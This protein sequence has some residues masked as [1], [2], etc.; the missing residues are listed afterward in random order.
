MTFVPGV[1]ASVWEGVAAVAVGAN[2]PEKGNYIATNSYPINTVVDITNLENGKTVRL[3]VLSGLETPGLL[4]VISRDAAGAIELQSQTL[5]R[6]R[7]TQPADPIAFSRFANGR[8][9]SGDPDHDPMA[10]VALNGYNPFSFEPV[11]EEHIPANRKTEEA[12]PVPSVSV[13]PASAVQP[14]NTVNSG[15]VIPATA[16]QPAGTVQPATVAQPASASPFISTASFTNAGSAVHAAEAFVDV[17]VGAPVWT[18]TVIAETKP[19]EANP[20]NGDTAR[21]NRAVSSPPPYAIAPDYE[22]VFVPAETR[23]PSGNTVTPDSA[24]FIP[25]IKIIETNPVSTISQVIPEAT[26]AARDSIDPS[27]FID[28]IPDAPLTARFP[29]EHP[30]IPEE[31]TIAAVTPHIQSFP[32]EGAAIVASINTAPVQSVP[33]GPVFSAPSISRLESGMYYL[34]L[35]AY[36]REETVR[37]ELSRIDNNLPLAV[38]QGGNPGDP[39]YRILIGPVNLGE[40]GALLQRFKGSYKDAYIRLGN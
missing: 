29:E 8:S 17:P 5:G 28:S 18:E 37:S 12:A 20:V 2:L 34:Q 9:T 35:A 14:A 11:S 31:L 40:S 10:F 22:L 39:V 38:M 27:L 16:A 23:I 13:A 19:E 33:Q 36:S 6:I 21:E 32:P 7:M 3:V 25:E 1:S 15:T 24:Y 30:R 26:K 4:A